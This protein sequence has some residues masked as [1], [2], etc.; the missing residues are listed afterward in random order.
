M[1]IV[2]AESIY[3][4]VHKQIRNLVPGKG[5]QRA[6][7]EALRRRLFP[8]SLQDRRITMEE[9][10][11]TGTAVK[12]PI[13]EGGITR[14]YASFCAAG[15]TPDALHIPETA[16][17]PLFAY[18]LEKG[19]CFR[20]F[21]LDGE[22]RFISDAAP[23]GLYEV[24]LYR[25]NADIRA[26]RRTYIDADAVA[27][28]G[29]Y[30][31]NYYHWFADLVGRLLLCP[32]LQN[33]LVCTDLRY[34]YQRETL[35]LLGIE[36]SRR[37]P[38]SSY[39]LHQFKRL[40]V[41]SAPPFY[42]PDALQALGKFAEGIPAEPGGPKRLYISRGDVP[43]RRSVV[44]EHDLLPVLKDYGFTRMVFSNYSVAQQVALLRG[45]EQVVFPQGAAVI[46]MAFCRPETRFLECWSPFFLD[47]TGPRMVSLLGSTHH[48][49]IGEASGESAGQQ[50]PYRIDPGVFRQALEALQA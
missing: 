43:G 19:S 3:N 47:T 9:A 10:C 17:P 48:T 35:D 21:V 26:S 34:P 23:A 5:R 40:H 28:N 16:Y 30:T 32:N 36:E 12:R 24:N 39:S 29:T 15:P 1:A 4:F 14:A 11:S 33:M 44:N 7:I 42:S 41:V 31:D 37:I 20:S 27:L 45:A 25:N 13:C 38:I 18:T 6:C 50:S 8:E 2:N 46:N 49:L 22:D